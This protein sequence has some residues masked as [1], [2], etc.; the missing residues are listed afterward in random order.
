MRPAPFFVDPL[1]DCVFKALLGDPANQDLLLDFLNGVLRPAVPI[2]AVTIQNPYNP[3]EFVG[4]K[5]TIVDVKAT[6]SEGVV[7]Q[8]EV[9]VRVGKTLPQ[10]ILYTWAHV[11]HGQIGESDAYAKLRPACSIWILEGSLFG[12]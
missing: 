2:V 1:V 12:D 11:Y 4:D 5:E 3:K 9:Q 8:I 10:R 6:D 7:Y